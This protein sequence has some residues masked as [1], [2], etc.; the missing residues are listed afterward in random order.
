[1]PEKTKKSRSRKKKNKQIKSKQK[2]RNKADSKK[3][4]NETKSYRKDSKEWTWAQVNVLVKDKKERKNKF[5]ILKDIVSG[6]DERSVHKYSINLPHGKNVDKSKEWKEAFFSILD[7]VEKKKLEWVDDKDILGGI[8]NLAN[9]HNKWLRRPSDFKIKY[10]NSHRQFSAFLRHLLC[11]YETPLFMDS[12]WINQKVNISQE[13]RWFI[14]VGNGKNIRKCIGLPLT[15]T[16][17]MAHQFLLAPKNL[18]IKQAFRHSQIIGLG[19]N[20]RISKACM[21]THL[22]RRFENDDFWVSVIRFFIANPMLDPRQ[23]GPII[24]YVQA[25]KFDEHLTMVEGQ[26]VEE[27]P[28]PGFS[29]SR[30]E[31]EALIRNVEEWHANLNSSRRRSYGDAEWDH[32]IIDDFSL[33][34]GERGKKNHKIW[35][36]KQLL[37]AKQLSVEG[38]SMGHC[39]SSYAYSC[40]KYR[41]TI[42]SMLLSD[43][44]GLY[45]N[46]LTVEV[47]FQNKHV[48]QAKGKYNDEPTE[49]QMKVLN[50]WAAK[51][52][53]SVSRYLSY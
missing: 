33:E 26:M 49:Q 30:R 9:F 46:V 37:S 12:A 24:D 6:K 14:D 20:D 27:I 7:F 53:L 34:E 13:H 45:R 36:I 16:K 8:C 18:S 11:Q 2:G 15:L 44:L 38:K 39:V 19:G 42:W 5:H 43:R 41:T 29:M 28:Q 1:M 3:Y 10:H 25:Q 21:E 35:N 52:E 23:C 51:E 50:L 31:P 22:G 32:C 47:D 48:I 17:K 40:S 4:K